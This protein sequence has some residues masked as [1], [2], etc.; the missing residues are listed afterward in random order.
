MTDPNE[1]GY[2][3]LLRATPIL[4][5][6]ETDLDEDDELRLRSRLVPRH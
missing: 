3:L 2:E 5:W 4:A 1:S 6:L